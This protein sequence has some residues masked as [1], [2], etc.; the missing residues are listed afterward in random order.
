MP[1][2]NY[3][4]PAKMPK[5]PKIPMPKG[6]KSS[7]KGISMPKAPKVAGVKKPKY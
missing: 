6:V 2:K 4:K 3:A 5:A 7:S 1:T